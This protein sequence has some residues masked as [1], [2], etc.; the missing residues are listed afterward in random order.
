M[1]RWLLLLIV[2]YTAFNGWYIFRTSFEV[3]GQRIWC[4][5]DDAMISMRYA[6]NLVQGH[7]LVW[8]P[9]E[10]P[11]QGYSNLGV[12]LVMAAVHLLPLSKLHSSL[13]FQLI[14]LVSLLAIAVLS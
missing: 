7:G 3:D 10:T 12:T 8:N 13:V 4:L 2:A 14:N 11:V 1:R 9:G 6:E 5:W